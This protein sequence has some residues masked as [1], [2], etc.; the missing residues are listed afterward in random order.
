M[1]KSPRRIGEILIMEGRI[2]EAQLM[3]ALKDQ[4]VSGKFLGGI[5]LDRGLITERELILALAE[6]FN[7]PFVELKNENIDME[8]ARK[9][10]ASLIIDH[11]CFPFKEDESSVS[12]AIANPLN[13]VA[14][15]KLEEE[16]SPR[17]I[18]LVLAC[19]S[20]LTKMA[21][22]YR[23]YISERIQRLLKR[24]PAEGSS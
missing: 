14:L 24:K 17:T 8:L 22:E 19:E 23:R 1:E 6:Q 7:L 16:A 11:K 13:A 3:D 20:E 9:F 21:Q 15:A 2:T 4:K 18:R 10:S 12:V 5:L